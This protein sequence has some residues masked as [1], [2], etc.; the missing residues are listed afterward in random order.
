M[1][2]VT[3]LTAVF[4]FLAA[5]AVPAA[6]APGDTLRRAFEAM[7]EADWQEA[8]DLAGEAG[9]VARDIIEWHRLR[10]GRGD[11][12]AVLGFLEARPDWP[13]LPWLRRQ[14]EEAIAAAGPETALAFF[15]P[16]VPETMGGALAKSAALFD[17]GR[18]GEAEAE[19]VLAWRTLGTSV[20]Q[21]DLLLERHRALLAPHHEARLDRALWEG[22]EENARRMFP[23]VGPGHRALAE[24]RLAL[25]AQRPGVDALIEAVPASLAESPGLAFDR[26]VWRDRKGRD[27]DAKALLDATSTSAAALGLPAR[28]ADRREALARDEMRD[29]DPELA[30]R[31]AANHFL[32]EGSQF[33][34][35]EWLAGFIAL[36]KLGDPAR[37]LV[38]FGRFDA[39]VVTPI[40]RGRAGYWLGRAHEAA[41]DGEAARA[42][43]ADAARWQTSF[44][45]LLAAERAGLA[46]DASLLTPPPA[47][48][49]DAAFTDSSVFDAGRMLLEAGE[50]D[51]GERFLTHLTESLNEADAAR[52]S[53]MALEMERPHLALR[54]A[55]RAA[56]AGTV[57]PAAYYPMHPVAELDLPA[58]AELVLSIARRESE[59]DPRVASGAGAQ[60]LMQVMPGTARDVAGEL[61]IED[62]STARLKDWR[63]SARLG[64]AYLAGLAARFD[65][66][67]V[68]MS[69]GYNAGPGRPIQWVER[70]GDPRRG[71]VDVVEWIEH[72]PFSE[73]RNY[74]MRV[75]ESLPVYRAK[76]GL[77]PH[78]VPFSQELKGATLYPPSD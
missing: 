30:Y 11:A 27:A 66:N 41:G 10:A 71:A 47:T 65:G 69:A 29:G 61:G 72:V 16:R 1:Q 53:A 21:Q 8:L 2:A 44:Y 37:A 38:H 42:A 26:F 50:V 33:N 9:P 64:A 49:L 39:G 35:L 13:G 75:A 70:F 12:E 54:I 77:A 17:A 28:W 43:Y 4:A 22:W 23:L 52:L 67:V 62:H 73:T 25:Q 59:F 55:K 74:I 46:F 6:A 78:P 40:S 68:L 5:L 48:W 3:R 19:L 18:T 36:T 24:A 56:D 76:L 15:G 58:P 45:G 14:S 63:Y 60:G 31:L 32:T 57:L 20:A 51:L 7:R 34:D